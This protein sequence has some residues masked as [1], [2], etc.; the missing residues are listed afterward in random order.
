MRACGAWFEGSLAKQDLIRQLLA[1][2]ATQRL[3]NLK[4]GAQDIK[5]HP[6]FTGIVWRDLLTREHTPSPAPV[7]V[8][9]PFSQ[10]QHLLVLSWNRHL[11]ML[12]SCR[13]AKRLGVVQAILNVPQPLA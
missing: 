11:S 10:A 6:V 5:R 1:V 7:A 13:V 3:G 12:A 8:V 2:D 9:Q 4:G